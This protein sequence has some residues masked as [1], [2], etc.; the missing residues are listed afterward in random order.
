ML[1]LARH[2]YSWTGDPRYFDYYERSLLNHRI[3][4]IHPQNGFTQYYLSMTPGAWKTFNRED[5]DFWCCTGTGVEEY[6][7]LNDSIYWHDG[8]GVYINLFIPS[9][10]NWKDKG[11][12]IRQETKFPEQQSTV[13]TISVDRPTQMPIR[14]RVPEWIESSS[15]KLNGK[16]LEASASGGSYLVLN[17]QWKT[18]DKIEMQLPMQLR[19]ESMPDDHKMLAVL[20][21][22]VVLAGDLG[23]DGLNEQLIYGTNVPRLQRAGAIDVPTLK[24]VSGDPSASIKPAGKPLTFQMAARQKEVTLIPINSLF[25]RRYTIYWTVA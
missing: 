7:K 8:E 18:G 14:L 25:D 1:K 13:L 15:V 17:R 20:Y 24:D 6:S 9:E 4:T 22:P 16:P 10:L 2:L 11:L 23:A 12:R 19:T 3:G 21:G 5:G